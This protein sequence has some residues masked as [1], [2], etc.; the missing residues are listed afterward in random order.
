MLTK[1]KVVRD[2]G[3][4]K[5]EINGNLYNPLSFKSFR[6]NDKNVSEFY[7]AG[8]RLFSVLTSGITSALGVP[9]SLYGESWVGENKYD[10][11]KIDNQMDMFI[12][13]APDGY[14][15]PMIQLD[16]RDWYLKM[17]PELPNS[18]T[19]LSQM[20][21]DEKWKK[22][23]ADYLKSAI[24][25][26]ESKYGDRVY[27]YFLLCGTTTEW[28]SEKDFEEP[29]PIKEKG[30]KKWSGNENAKLP[31]LE[32]LNIK[33]D[34]FLSSD[35]NDV[36]MARKFHSETI[37]DLILYFTGEAQ[38]VIKHD[39]LLGLYYGYL[40]E[41]GGERLYN[42]GTLDY[43]KVFLSSD[44]DMISSPSAYEYRKVSDSSAYMLTKDT[45][46]AHNKLY[47][48]E[49]DHITHVAPDE[50]K[51]GLDE[52]SKNGIIVKIPG[53]GSK[54]KTE[55]E[56]LNVMLRDFVLCSANRNA[57]WWFDMFDGWF[58]SDNM[59]KTIA[60]MIEINKSLLEIKTESVAEVAVFAEGK[61][62][63]RARKSSELATFCLSNIRRTLAECGA[64]YDI[65]S[66]G[67]LKL[68]QTDNYKLYIFINQYDIKEDT[69]KLIEEKCKKTGKTVLWLYAPNYA[70]NGKLNVGNISEITGINV[71]E[72][73]E[74]NGG[75]VY[76]NNI[77]D[78]KIAS[79]YF[80]VC[81]KNSKALA[82]FENQKVCTAVKETDGYKSIYS[83]LCNLPSNLLRDILKLAGIF[84]YSEKSN[85]Y[86]YVNS[87]VKGVYNASGEDSVINLIQDGKYTDLIENKTY[88][89][90]N[91]KL[92]LPHKEIN[93][94]LLRREENE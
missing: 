13:N 61:S 69:R 1:S 70:T 11:S 72:N 12:R 51:D 84:L 92:L 57:L 89:C 34:V 52:N 26:I 76:N 60:H 19:H 43:E 91:G 41:L 36:Y 58:R 67:D 68:E 3:I 32:R 47:F 54:F 64:P 73:S 2:N 86:T 55:T 59:M 16:T 29:H 45:L 22:D 8:I 35:E 74:S 75:I 42:N 50:I 82:F 40:L 27:G 48:L 93:A 63:Y 25:H 5:I 80:S 30:F 66:I 62:M 81:D 15:A 37:S 94:F 31:T 10:F 33:G 6:P 18:F 83:A 65:Y 53:A 77:Y 44:I 24:L 79:P 14:F 78:Y 23:A 4:L 87:V 20:A 85:V 49:F 17:R 9:Y 39:K 28:F 71:C 21:Y 88:V 46:D 56:S 7:N 38:S 90:K